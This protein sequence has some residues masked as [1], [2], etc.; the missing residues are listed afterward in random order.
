MDCF[1]SASQENNNI[2]VAKLINFSCK[3]ASTDD[4]SGI[5]KLNSVQ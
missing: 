2:I 4:N 3:T 5:I 1:K